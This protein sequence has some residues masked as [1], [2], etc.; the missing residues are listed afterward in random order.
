M[1]CTDRPDAASICGWP[2]ARRISPTCEPTPPRSSR[3]APLLDAD[4][5]PCGSL[6]IIDVADRA[7]AEGFAAGDPYAN[8]G[9]FES[10]I[11]RPYRPVFKDGGVAG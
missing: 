6:L 11:L 3:P 2:P 1:I 5:D 7:D 4:G 8:A 9:L 10:V